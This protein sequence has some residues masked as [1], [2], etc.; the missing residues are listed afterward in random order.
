MTMTINKTT[1][2]SVILLV[3]AISDAFFLKGTR[4]NFKTHVNFIKPTFWC[5]LRQDEAYDKK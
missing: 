4:D 1:R 3:F 2:C 5:C